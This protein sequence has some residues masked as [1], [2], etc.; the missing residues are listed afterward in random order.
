MLRSYV[1]LSE[2]KPK[3]VN[4]FAVLRETM[5]TCFGEP[6]KI[7]CRRKPKIFLQWSNQRRTYTFCIR[8]LCG[9]PTQTATIS[10][11][12]TKLARTNENCEGEF[13]NCVRGGELV[14]NRKDTVHAQRM[15]PCPLPARLETNSVQKVVSAMQVAKSYHIVDSI[16]HIRLSNSTHQME[17]RW[18]GIEVT[19]NTWDFQGRVI[20]DVTWRLEDSLHKLGKRKF[21]CTV[22]SPFY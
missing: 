6:A 18:L 15:L 11:I 14:Q 21:N 3:L 10:Y 17:A 12:M 1:V 2:A 19:N 8:W 16:Q 22:L 4:R 20:E 13:E 5:K 9:D 7:L